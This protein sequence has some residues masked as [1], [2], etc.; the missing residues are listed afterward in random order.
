L[1]AFSSEHSVIHGFSFIHL[2]TSNFSTGGLE[3]PI[4]LPYT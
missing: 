1:V 4:L 2:L 3:D